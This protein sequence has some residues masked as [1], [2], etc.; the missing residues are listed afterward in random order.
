MKK[1]TLKIDGLEANLLLFALDNYIGVDEDGKLYGEHVE[2]L[3]YS[4]EYA[5]SLR[6]RLFLIHE[7]P[8]EE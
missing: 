1:P 8:Q 7:H 4:L 3:G 2:R 5:Q 6:D